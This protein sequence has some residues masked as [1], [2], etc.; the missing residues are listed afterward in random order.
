MK[1][2]LIPILLLALLIP[3]ITKAYDFPKKIFNI[4]LYENLDQY[5]EGYTKNI[6]NLWNEKYNFYWLDDAIGIEKNNLF[7]EYFGA[8]KKEDVENKIIYITGSKFEKFSI[9]KKDSFEKF[10][11]SCLSKKNTILK[12]IQFKYDIDDR[13]LIKKIIRS[14]PEETSLTFVNVVRINSQNN[15][16]T[17]SIGCEFSRLENHYLSRLLYSLSSKEELDFMLDKITTMMDTKLKAID[18]DLF[19][20]DSSGL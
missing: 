7:D 12:M 2:K 16:E 17:L 1:T 14:K 15:K 3:N 13:Y 10:K 4:Y 18:F 19:K 9:T 5:L 20:E 8:I 6:E 11:T